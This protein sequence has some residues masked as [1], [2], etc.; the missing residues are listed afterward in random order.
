[1]KG[2]AKPHHLKGLHS[3][4]A[5]DARHL[6]AFALGLEAILPT[7]IDAAHALAQAFE[8]LHELMGG[9]EATLS[10]LLPLAGGL[11]I[12]LVDGPPLASAGNVHALLDAELTAATSPRAS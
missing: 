8:A 7:G 5:D 10:V 3:D 6:R 11:L 2:F 4:S 9:C 12:A 1:L